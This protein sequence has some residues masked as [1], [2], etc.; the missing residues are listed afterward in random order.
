[1]AIKTRITGTAEYGQYMR[2]LLAGDPGS[3]KTLMSS[4]FPNPYYISAEGGLMSLAR[5]FLPAT[6]LETTD[7]LREILKV[8]R[9][10]PEVRAK[11]L[12]VTDA[13]NGTQT[14]IDT[15]VIDTIDE[16]SKLFTRERL[17]ARNIEA[18]ENYKDWG[19][20]SDKVESVVRAFR[21]LPLNVVFTC[22]L[23]DVKDEQTG[24]VTY[25]PALA[26]QTARYLPGAVDLAFV[27]QSRS[28]IGVEDGKSAR[29]VFRY[30]QTYSDSI[31]PWAKDRS[32]RLPHEFEMN[33]EDDYQRMFD[34]IYGG[35]D[36]EFSK[37]RA[38]AAEK[39]ERRV[40]EIKDKFVQPD[41][42]DPLKSTDAAAEAEFEVFAKQTKTNSK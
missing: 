24:A 13:S 14:R 19:W 35:L 15:I 3:G 34:A 26:G 39:V 7:D 28:S 36:E 40:E 16:V 2:A 30:A 10:E 21:N 9:Q 32:G 41:R 22:H 1:M 4:T 8:L 6:E 18:F 37:A 27:L 38:E 12:D 33:F 31:Y 11:M 25:L 20:L 17:T 29:K 23:K 42:P 5:R